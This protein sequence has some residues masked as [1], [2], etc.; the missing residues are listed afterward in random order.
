MGCCLFASLLAGA[1]RLAA[2]IWWIA[3]PSRF[4]LAFH[5]AIGGILGIIFLPWT[6]LMYLAVVPGGVQGFNWFWIAIGL[7]IDFSVY[8]GN[9]RAREQ[10][11]YGAETKSI[12]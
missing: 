2:I 8:A 5:S 9:I 6:T 3:Q 1:P 7:A 11:K 12:V 4:T 10:Q